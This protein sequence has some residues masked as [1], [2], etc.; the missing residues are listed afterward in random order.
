MVIVKKLKYFSFFFQNIKKQLFADCY[1][2]HKKIRKEYKVYLLLNT[3]TYQ[4]FCLTFLK[5]LDVLKN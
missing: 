5:T 4:T 2:K 1:K 3:C